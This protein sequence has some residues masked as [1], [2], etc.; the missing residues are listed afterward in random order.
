MEL[1]CEDGGGRIDVWL[2]GGLEGYSR[3]DIQKRIDGGYVSVNGV[4]AIKSYKVKNGDRIQM[5]I[6]EPEPAGITAQDINLDILYEDAYIIVVDKPRGMVVHPGNGNRDNTLANALAYHCAE[7]LSDINGA[8]RPGIVHRLDKD[9]SG[10]IVAAKTNGA[11]YKLAAEFKERRVRK[12]YNAIVLGHV[13]RDSGRIEMPVGRHAADRTRMAVQSGGRSAVTLFKV[14]K[15]LPC[16]YSWLELEILTGRTHQIRVHLARIGHPV[17]GDP[18]YGRGKMKNV[19][20]LEPEPFNA[21]GGGYDG[22]RARTRGRGCPLTA[23]YNGQLLHSTV[24]EFTHPATGAR[25]SFTSAL[26]VYFTG[27][28]HGP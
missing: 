8:V 28:C 4:T 13:D 10:L 6:P 16:R 25:L 23:D 11:H 12:V 2:A 15:R 5:K 26:P 21:E 17:A 7:G 14:V 24:L 27:H 19:C 1:V 18:V 20:P 9:T 22:C 3:S